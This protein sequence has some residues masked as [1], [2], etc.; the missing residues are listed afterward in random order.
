MADII[1]KAVRKRIDL[2]NGSH[3]FIP[4][5]EQIP[6]SVA[7]DQYQEHTLYLRNGIDTNRTTH[8]RNVPNIDND[9]TIAVERIEKLQVKTMAEQ[10]QERTYYLKNLDPPPILPDGSNDPAHERVHYVRYF[11]NNDT[12]SNTWVDVELI[13]TLKITVAAEQ[14][15]EW[16]LYLRHDVPGDVIENPG[17]NYGPVTVGFCSEALERAVKDTDLDPPYRLDPFQNIIQFNEE[18]GTDTEPFDRIFITPHPN[19]LQP[20][21]CWLMFTGSLGSNPESLNWIGVNPFTDTDAATDYDLDM[22]FVDQY[23]EPRTYD[24]TGTGQLGT[25]DVRGYTRYEWQA[26]WGGGFPAGASPDWLQQAQAITGLPITRPYHFDWSSYGFTGDLQAAFETWF[27]LGIATPAPFA[28]VR[29]TALGP[30]TT[31]TPSGRY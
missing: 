3:V 5:L 21:G 29:M 1:R 24:D 23:F 27:A 9:A 6:F 11:E 13:D 18:T 30:T 28:V 17:V 22:R 4:V 25:G 12:G 26:G 8:I 15:Q 7:A 31:G 14:Y 16:L 20:S 19:G 2:P 10:A